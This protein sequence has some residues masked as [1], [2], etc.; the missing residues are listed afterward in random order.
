VE[1]W[2]RVGSEAAVAPPQP[3]VSSEWQA[4]PEDDDSKSKT[5][6]EDKWRT[7]TRI[8]HPSCC[9]LGRPKENH[10]ALQPCR[11]IKE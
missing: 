2:R 6:K 4:E 7:A 10:P 8:T 9:G 3:R 1:D 11:M 5:V